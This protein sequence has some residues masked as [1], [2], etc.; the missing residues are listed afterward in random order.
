MFPVIGV[1]DPLP[2]KPIERNVEWKAEDPENETRVDP[3]WS[4]VHYL[5]GEKPIL[6]LAYIMVLASYAQHFVGCNGKSLSINSSSH[7]ALNPIEIKIEG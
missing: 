5:R 3:G 2:R 6:L 4:G 7:V 1:M